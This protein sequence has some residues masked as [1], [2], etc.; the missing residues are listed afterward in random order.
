MSSL[1]AGQKQNEQAAFLIRGSP[2]LL[3]RS[4]EEPTYLIELTSEMTGSSRLIQAAR[5]RRTLRV[6]ITRSSHS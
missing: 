1:S 3:A 4:Q 5:A 2:T 6:L